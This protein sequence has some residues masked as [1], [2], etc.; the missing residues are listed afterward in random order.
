MA[1]PIL[2]APFLSGLMALLE[3]RQNFFEELAIGGGVGGRLFGGL[4]DL[5]AFDHDRPVKAPG[6]ESFEDRRES[7]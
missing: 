2:G 4:S 7:R 5:A 6:F 3:R 1:H